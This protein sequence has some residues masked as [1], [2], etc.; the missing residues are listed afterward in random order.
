MMTPSPV[1][2]RERLWHVS[3]EALHPVSLFF[4]RKLEIT[5]LGTELDRTTLA[6]GWLQPHKLP[7]N[8]VRLLK[9]VRVAR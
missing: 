3:S 5:V 9:R 2:V 6:E 1:F 7:P 8:S 4:G